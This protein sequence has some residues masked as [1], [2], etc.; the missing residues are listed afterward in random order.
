MID[1]TM[2]DKYRVSSVKRKK[3][4][5]NRF[6]GTLIRHDKR[7]FTLEDTRGIRETFL[8]VDIR[9]GEYGLNKI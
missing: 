4:N 6:T 5:L 3:K 7:H 1:F 2:G 9:I 8:K